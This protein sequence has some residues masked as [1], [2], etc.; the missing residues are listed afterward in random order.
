MKEAVVEIKGAQYR[1]RENDV[2]KVPKLD[3]NVGDTVKF[4][5]VLLAIKDGKT[6]VGTPYVEGAECVAK[7]LETKKDKKLIVYKY[8]PKKRYYRMKGHRQWYTKIK[9]EQL[10]L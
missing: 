9:I 8:K 4:T 3:A 7:V 6:I 1:V 2:V 10:N 5:T